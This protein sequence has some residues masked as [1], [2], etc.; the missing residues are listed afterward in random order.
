MHEYMVN[1]DTFVNLAR[2]RG[3]HMWEVP[4]LNLE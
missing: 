1:M 3:V 2:D 4:I